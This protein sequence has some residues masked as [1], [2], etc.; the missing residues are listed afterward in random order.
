MANT[1]AGCLS[2]VETI[3]QSQYESYIDERLKRRSTPISNIIPKNNISVFQ[4]DTT[5]E[6]ILNFS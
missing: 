2:A 6:T 3:D 1:A 4:E 5:N